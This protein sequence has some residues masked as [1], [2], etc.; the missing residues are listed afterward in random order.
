M[1]STSVPQQ[2]LPR[3]VVVM[4]VTGTGKSSVGRALALGGRFE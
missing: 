2:A 4:G 3:R 1:T